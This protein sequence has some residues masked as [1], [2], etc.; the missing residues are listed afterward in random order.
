MQFS[1]Y[2]HISV[3]LPV[4]KHCRLISLG[5]HLYLKDVPSE[6][7]QYKPNWI[8]DLC[9]YGTR[10]YLWLQSNVQVYV[11]VCVCTYL[12]SILCINSYT[13]FNWII[14]SQIIWEIII[15]QCWIWCTY[16]YKFTVNFGI[17]IPR[18]T[19]HGLWHMTSSWVF[20]LDFCF[21][22]WLIQGLV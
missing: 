12:F 7:I 11:C 21:L 8:Y 22:I 1:K 18:Y 15:F 10:S 19:K 14:P 13:K 2:I 4:I 20:T 6:P 5:F 17:I 9:N 3:S 16:M